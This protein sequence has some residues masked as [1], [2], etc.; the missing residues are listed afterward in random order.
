MTDPI[1][2]DP[3]EL[4]LVLSYM[5]IDSVVGWGSEPFTPPPDAR[6]AFYE[7][8]RALL[9]RAERLVPEHQEGDVE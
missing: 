5:E 1:Q 7:Q 3:R 2:V 8:G 6:D 4:A 9:T